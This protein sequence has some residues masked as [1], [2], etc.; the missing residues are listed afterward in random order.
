MKRL[1]LKII[2][3]KYI[4]L[5]GIIAFS[6]SKKLLTIK[7]ESGVI[8]QTE[9]PIALEIKLCKKL[10]TAAEEGRLVLTDPVYLDESASLI[11]GSLVE[12][13]NLAW[14]QPAFPTKGTR[15]P[16]NADKSLILRCYYK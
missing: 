14:V 10:L 5:S 3:L 12:Y 4:L 8:V 15:F 13:P 6:H 9:S 11:P 1:I 16:L 7:D 2:I